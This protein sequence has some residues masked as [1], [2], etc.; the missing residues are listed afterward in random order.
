MSR[1]L[2]SIIYFNG[3]SIIFDRESDLCRLDIASDRCDKDLRDVKIWKEGTGRRRKVSRGRFVTAALTTP[4]PIRRNG[5]CL[6]CA[7]AD[8]APP[9]KPRPS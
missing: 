8:E 7:G 9:H 3:S 2:R 1:E 6:V 5:V 4:T